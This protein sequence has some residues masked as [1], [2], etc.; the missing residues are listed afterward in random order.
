MFEIHKSKLWDAYDKNCPFYQHAKLSY[1]TFKNS[2]ET[3]TEIIVLWRQ[4][5]CSGLLTPCHWRA[6]QR[7]GKCQVIL[8]GLVSPIYW[9]VLTKKLW[10][11]MRKMLKNLSHTNWHHALM[12]WDVLA[13]WFECHFWR[14]NSSTLHAHNQQFFIVGISKDFEVHAGGLIAVFSISTGVSISNLQKSPSS[15]LQC[16]SNSWD[17]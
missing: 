12:S 3:G 7:L 4:F 6:I 1:F 13:T 8:N 17:K 15:S 16:A 14:L 9:E 2:H 11:K 5:V 10:W